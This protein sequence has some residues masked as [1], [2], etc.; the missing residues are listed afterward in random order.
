MKFRVRVSPSMS[1]HRSLL[2]SVEDRLI[3]MPAKARAMNGLSPGA[4]VC[5]K[6]KS[7]S[8]ILLQ[9]SGAYIDD[10]QGDDESVYVSQDTHDLLK[11]EQ[12]SS[13]KPAND[14]LIGCDPEFF[15]VDKSTGFTISASHFFN[16]YGDV[17][18]DQG[19]AEL[20]PRPNFK[21]KG[22]SDELFR[23]IMKAYQHINGRILYR[24]NDIHLIAASHYNHASAGY[25]IHFGLP[26]HMLIDNIGGRRLLTHI[27]HILDYYVGISAILPEGDEDYFRRSEKFSRYGKPG[28]HRVDLTTLEYR[29]PGGHLLRH[30]VLSS[31]ILSIGI[32]VMKDVLSRL[33]AYSD[34]FSQKIWF[35]DY[36][37]LRKLYPRL[38]DQSE[39][40][41]SIVAHTT[42]KA[43]KHI[44]NILD[45]LSK[46]IGFQENGNQIISY[47]D[48][49]LN[50]TRKRQKFD[51]NMEANWRL[52]NERQSGS[53][54]VLQASK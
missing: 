44:D 34:D 41:D 42:D 53:M 35:K 14:I 2:G 21:E 30:P 45:D 29:V 19:L 17:G 24:K 43:M 16:Y 54:A 23:L 38:P 52:I 49:V 22:V 15:L 51:E 48:Y 18:A 11:L 27:T 7:N 36:A 26:S 3:R 12:I 8:P 20:R 50:Y 40:H 4:Y 32:T 6:G 47:F 10:A 46:M 37:D 39:V 25:H 31:G 5:F 9:T 1:K 13:V 33:Q 28:D